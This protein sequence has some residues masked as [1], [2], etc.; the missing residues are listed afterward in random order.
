[1]SPNRSPFE[2]MSAAQ[3]AAYEDAQLGAALRCQPAP[4]PLTVLPSK[5]GGKG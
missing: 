1:M 5:I 3:R 2:T 4:C